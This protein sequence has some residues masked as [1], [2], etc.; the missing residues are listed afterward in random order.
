MAVAAQNASRRHPH[1][2]ASYSV[3]ALIAAAE[4]GEWPDPP[5]IV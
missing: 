2:V 3:N 5:R 1:P 4:R